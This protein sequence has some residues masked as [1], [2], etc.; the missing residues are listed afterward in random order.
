MSPIARDPGSFRD[1]SGTVFITDERVLRSIMASAAP[2]YEAVRASGILAELADDGLVISQRAVDPGALGE[3]A[4]GAVHVVEHPLLPF[5]SYPYEWCFGALK[6]AA[7][8]HLVI[9][10]RC[11]DRGFSMSDASAYNVQFIGSTPLFIDTLSFRPYVEGEL[12][13][14][15]RQFCEQFLN[16]LLLR[17]ECKVPF[18]AWYR[19]N[20]EGIPVSELARIL[21]FRAK[22]KWNV[23]KHVVLQA[24]FQQSASGSKSPS[25]SRLRKIKLPLPTF[26]GMLT[27]L[28]RWI[29]RLAPVG[30]AKTQWQDYAEANSYAA[31][32][33]DQ[34][35]RFV[36]EFVAALQPAMVWD[37]GCNTGHFARVCLE[38]GARTCVGFDFDIGA[39]E[40]AYQRAKA[41]KLNFFPVLLDATNP[42]PN[43]GWAQSERKGLIERGPA[44]ALV[45]LAL[46]HHLAIAKN[47][48]LDS[49]VDWFVG[50]APSGVIEFVEKSDPM[51]QT[52]LSL[53]KDIFPYYTKDV[54]EHLL[55]QRAR[56]HRQATISVAGRT[57]YWYD[58]T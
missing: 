28:R 58:A 23:L 10:E 41:Q 52:M 19:G 5:V 39:V 35:S 40:I 29:E 32:E 54:F 9:H 16:P 1:P 4:P 27:G 17:A 12:W 49:L 6:D 55:S 2:N 47:I 53:R 46:V 51:V 8:L 11:L 37:L 13:T 7:L 50:L 20:L 22:F 31:E 15:H 21:P 33:V 42:S 14:G 56:I 45:A 24:K 34:K 18:N 43:Q 57:V 44:D 26:L 25:A 48:P 30:L 3:L 38:H 36:A